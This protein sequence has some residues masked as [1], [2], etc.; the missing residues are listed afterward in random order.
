MKAQGVESVSYSGGKAM[1]SWEKEK[2]SYSE[3]GLPPLPIFDPTIDYQLKYWQLFQD[4][5][6]VL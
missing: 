4:N 5:E 1:G 3:N 6:S 2:S